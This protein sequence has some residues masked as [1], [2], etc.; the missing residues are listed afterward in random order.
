MMDLTYT[1][2]GLQVTD[3]MREAASHKLGRLHRLEKR[4]TRL[5]LEIIN[6]HHP[7]NEALKRIEA[8]LHTP[9]KT[10]RA[11][12]EASDVP[13]ALDIVVERLERQ[14]RD[15]HGRRISLLHRRKSGIESANPSAAPADASE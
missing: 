7:A 8:T 3:D 14:L 13:T 12:A 9:R 4:A 5:D 6:E 2:R 10:F 1:G 11:S 15:N